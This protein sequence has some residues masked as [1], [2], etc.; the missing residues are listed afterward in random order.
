MNLYEKECRVCAKVKPMEDFYFCGNNRD[1]LMGKCKVCQ[2]EHTSRN[3][4][5]AYVHK[6]PVYKSVA[7]SLRGAKARAVKSNIVFNITIEDLGDLPTRCPVL[8]VELIPGTRGGANNNSPS[9]DRFDSTKGYVAGN[10]YVISCRA[11][12]LKNNGTLEEHKLI[13]DWMYK[14]IDKLA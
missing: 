4:K 2:R 11:N 7:K 10:V 3:H 8:G 13:Y 1:N 12:V 5:E 9:I 14:I 6:S